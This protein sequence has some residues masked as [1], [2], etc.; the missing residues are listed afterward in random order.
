[1]DC[2]RVEWIVGRQGGLW[3]GRVDCERVDCGRV[4]WILGG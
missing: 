2:E 4:G 3:E 1:M